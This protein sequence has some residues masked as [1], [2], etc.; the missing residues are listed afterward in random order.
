MPET[1]AA[2]TPEPAYAGAITAT[3]DA[4]TIF[5]QGVFELE[6]YGFTIIAGVLSQA[7]VIALR[8]LGVRLE[9]ERGEDSAFLGTARHLS[10]LIPRDPAYFPMID[11]PRILPYIERLLGPDIILASLNSRIVRPQDPAQGLHGDIPAGLRRPGQPIMVNT[12]WMLD[13]WTVASGATRVV[14]GSHHMPQEMPPAQRHLP[15][16]LQ[17]LAPAGSVLIFDGRLWHGGGTNTGTQDRHGLFGHY[18]TGSWTSFQCD[19]NQDFPPAWWERLSARQR[20][21]LRMHDGVR[22]A[23]WVD[24]HG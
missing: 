13:D 3:P 5:E 2:R 19:P 4:A 6:T 14:P 8:A 11:H 15:Y 9:R 7:E 22:P 10:N 21:L 16:Q 12:V 1:L 20:R 24:D 18:R 17:A 23:R